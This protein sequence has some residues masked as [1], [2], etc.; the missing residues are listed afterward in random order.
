MS[1]YDIL[2]CPTCKVG[3][4]R[5]EQ[6]L[7]CPRCLR[8]Y[9]IIDNVPVLLPE[10]SVPTPY[11][12]V[13]QVRQGYDPWLHRV[14]LQSLP[15]D[16]ITLELGAGNMSFS[17]P[18]LIRMDITLTQYVDV[19][20][21][22]HAMPFLPETFSFIFSLAVMEH[23]RQP[24]V[25][26]QEM[27][28]TLRP[29][30]YVY[31]DCAFVFPYHS[32][33]HHY[34]NASHQGMEE[35]FKP[36]TC[37]RAGVAPYQMPSF[38][39]EALLSTYLALLK[40]FDD[41]EVRSLKTVVQQVLDQPLRSF[42]S[43]LSQEAARFCAACTYFFGVKSPA[44]SQLIPAVLQAVYARTPELQQRF[45]NL[46]DLG[47]P[48]NILAWAH[49]EGRQTSPEIAVALDALAPFHK[50][51]SGQD[52]NLQALRREPVV[53]QGLETGPASSVRSIR[54]MLDT[55]EQGLRWAARGRFLQR[56]KRSSL[57]QA[58]RGRT[59]TW[60]RSSS[61]SWTLDDVVNNG[62]RVTHLFPNDCYYAHLSIY[63]FALSF[64]RDALVLDAG[65]GTGYGAAYLADHGARFV[66][67]VD[68]GAKAIAFSRHYFPRTNLQFQEMNLERISGFPHHQ[69][70][71]VFCSNA[72]EHIA[73]PGT[74]FRSVWQLLKPEGL[75]LT[76]VPPIVNAELRAQNLANPHHLN[77]W[78]PR[79]WLHVLRQYFEDVQVYQ[80]W[81]E[82]P[83]IQLDFTN[84]PTETVVRETDFTFTPITLEQLYHVPTIGAIFVA[85]KPVAQSQLPFPGRRVT[86]VDDSFT[87]SHLAARLRHWQTLPARVRETV[88]RQGIV[89][90]G[91]KSKASV[92]RRL[93]IG[94]SS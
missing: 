59:R 8:T 83:G 62:E 38:A 61:S 9:P 80:H 42:D 13:L 73:H 69:F 90:A 5:D 66:Y 65:S 17:L 7:R 29:G 76:T 31:G 24:F 36:F 12:E 79:Q 28:N 47:V 48:E 60:A 23:L 56:L 18:N 52:G 1:L 91:Q 14:V 4:V 37:V 54:V 84:T 57:L 21:D 3:V 35:L 82:K 87:R 89:A 77:I 93:Q 41:P 78:S 55:L 85:R 15:P 86:F 33:P 92:L 63:H 10:G 20:G 16:A 27:Y 67:G 88:R 34:F 70:D 46:Y 30:G 43:R 25:A 81:F 19:V 64:V 39:I 50:N 94:R 40:P 26:A 44:A 11:D 49:T 45:P 72:L 74:F 53:V 32:H 22:A 68:L 2:A 6:T 75:L 71:V 58:L 51:G